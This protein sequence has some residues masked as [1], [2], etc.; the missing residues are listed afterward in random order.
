MSAKASRRLRTA[1]VVVLVLAALYTAY[2]YT[3]HRMVESKLDEIRTQGYP[4]TLTELDKWYPQPPPGK[5][6]AD[7]Y[8][9]A[10]K[11]FAPKLASDT[12]LPVVGDDRLPRKGNL[13]DGNMR[14]AASDYL[15]RNGQA[16]ALLHQGASFSHCR[17]PIDFTRGYAAVLPH[18]TSIHR[19]FRLLLLEAHLHAERDEGAQAGMSLLSA[20]ALA[21]SVSTEP[22]ETSQMVARG[23]S[24]RAA[25]DLETMLDRTS[26]PD[27]ALQG[28]EM[29]LS[30]SMSADGIIRG[31]AGE[32]CLAIDYN[33]HPVETTQVILDNK[34]LAPELKRTVLLL[35]LTGRLDIF[36]LRYLQSMQQFLQ[37]C[38]MPLIEGLKHS[39]DADPPHPLLDSLICNLS[40]GGDDRTTIEFMARTSTKVL[41]SCTSLAVER[42]RL[43]NGALPGSLS[44]LVPKFLDAFPTDPFDGQQLR[45]KKIAKGYVVYSVGEDGK[46]DGGD[47]KK[48]ITFTVGR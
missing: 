43:A 33:K 25:Y 10:F 19:G 47:E 13:M 3:L 18:L 1:L 38:R 9:Q 34:P 46:D 29:A 6:A 32:R 40:L 11:L 41:A 7:V 45:Y 21:Q 48:D 23:C 44:D 30:N 15:T 36:T 39:K 5:N 24:V 12:N 2:R 17:Y 42:Y 26:L 37:V 8:L 27:D 16:L 28:L 31:Y 35:Q 4:V 22:T 20:M 14:Q